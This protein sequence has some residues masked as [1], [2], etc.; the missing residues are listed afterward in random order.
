MNVMHLIA[1]WTD[2]VIG[3]PASPSASQ[4]LA[5]IVDE[6]K[7]LL[8]GLIDQESR[9][10]IFS[11]PCRVGPP[12]PPTYR[13]QG[14]KIESWGLQRLG[15]GVWNVEPSILIDNIFYAF[16]TIIGVPEPAPFVPIQDKREPT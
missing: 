14:D 9:Q 7:T 1:Q 8:M 10:H 5:R 13:K 3:S 2:R 6:G 15:P 4:P 16:V 12:L 11:F